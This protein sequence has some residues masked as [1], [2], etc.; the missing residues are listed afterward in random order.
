MQFAEAERDCTK[1]LALADAGNKGAV[2]GW[3]GCILYVMPVCGG[4]LPGTEWISSTRIQT[5]TVY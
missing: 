1:T 5:G 4:R 2:L 3:E